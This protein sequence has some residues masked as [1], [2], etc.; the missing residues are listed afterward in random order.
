LPDLLQDLAKLLNDLIELTAFDRDASSVLAALG[1]VVRLIE[2]DDRVRKIDVEVFSNAAI[3]QVIVRHE[4]QISAADTA[5]LLEVWT[6]LLRLR[7]LVQV[8]DVKRRP[9]NILADISARVAPVN[10]VSTAGHQT[11]ASSVQGRP[12]LV[13]N[14][15][16]SAEVIS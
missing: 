4:D 1:D 2:D 15:L 13:V 8:L 5:L 7:N 9:R 3:N 16:V 11:A 12:S 14:C 6:D 10:T